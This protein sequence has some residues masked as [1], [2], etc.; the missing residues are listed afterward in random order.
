MRPITPQLLLE[1][2]RLARYSRCISPET[3]EKALLVSWNRSREVLSQ[4][5]SM[6]L[7]T[8]NEKGYQLSDLGIK[9]LSASID[10]NLQGAHRIFLGYPPYAIVYEG[11]KKRGATVSEIAQHTGVSNV[12]ADIILRLI[13]W[14][15]P[16]L[17]KNPYTGR[18]Y[19]ASKERLSEEEFFK[20]L[21]EAYKELSAPS[22]FGMRRLYI[23]ISILR[24]YVCERLGLNKKTFNK[25]LGEIASNQEYGIELASAPTIGS[26]QRGQ[27]LFFLRHKDRPYFYVRVEESR[28]R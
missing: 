12:A 19:L 16:E 23:R 14:A 15:H 2:L 20:V 1:V 10:E 11:L 4:M 27:E 17:T 7:I 28:I 22:Y 8:T 18:Y 6:G 25:L 26:L 9:L 24:N 13:G 5:E 3:I 21:H